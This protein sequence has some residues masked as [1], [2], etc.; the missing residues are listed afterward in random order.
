MRGGH[1]RSG[2]P[3]DPR[4]LRRERDG[5]EWVTLPAAGRAGPAPTWPLAD[6]T[7]RERTLW[8]REWRRPQAVVW[9]RNG[10]ELELALYVRSVGAAER[11]DA[12]AAMRTLV[13]QQ[14]E[15][16]GISVPGLAGTG[17]GSGTR[18]TPPSLGVRLRRRMA[19]CRS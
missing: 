8:A 4:A 2:P 7:D 15:A 3:S 12:T 19:G 10:Q 13:R 1:S 18:R 17:G 5:L 6:Q 14:Q 9:E 16:L 11:V